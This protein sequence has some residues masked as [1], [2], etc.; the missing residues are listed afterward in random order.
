MADVNL[1]EKFHSI[2]SGNFGKQALPNR[3]T[4]QAR[5]ECCQKDKKK[6]SRAYKSHCVL[7][8][9]VQFAERQTNHAKLKGL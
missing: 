4:E 3:L 8:G 6:R 5:C 9:P 1:G 7:W 2:R